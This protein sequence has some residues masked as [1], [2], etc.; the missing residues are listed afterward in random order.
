MA[1]RRM[2]GVAPKDTARL[3]SDPVEMDATTTIR[4]AGC[5]G[6]GDTGGPRI[7]IQHAWL[8]CDC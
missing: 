3:D 1:A 2:G 6:A 7:A 8:R 5:A 4:A